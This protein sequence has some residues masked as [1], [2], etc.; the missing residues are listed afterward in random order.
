MDEVQMTT[1]K[2]AEHCTV[3]GDNDAD[4]AA[5]FARARLAVP[6]ETSAPPRRSSILK[7]E[8]DSSRNDVASRRV[9][10]QS[11]D[12]RAYDRC[13]GDNPSCSNGAPVSRHR[14]SLTYMFQFCR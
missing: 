8:A 4:A 14:M 7:L 13:V 9:S 10:F 3:G 6:D 1:R 5:G 12:I 2:G 11:V